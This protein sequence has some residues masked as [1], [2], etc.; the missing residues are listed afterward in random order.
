MK[1]KVMEMLA[2]IKNI[3]PKTAIKAGSI[4]VITI[5]GV[6]IASR[7]HS[8]EEEMLDEMLDDADETEE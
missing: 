3:D 1:E 5:V 2:K 6:V 7:L 4:A 8:D